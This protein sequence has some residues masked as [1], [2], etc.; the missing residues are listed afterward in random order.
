MYLAF[1]W[2]MPK[3]MRQSCMCACPPSSWAWQRGSR[4]QQ[5]WG[6]GSGTTATGGNAAC[7]LNHCVCS[8]LACAAI[9]QPPLTMHTTTAAPRSYGGTW[10]AVRRIGTEE[11]LAGY[12]K[13]MR[14][15][16]VQTAINAALMLMI[17][18]QASC[19]W[20]GGEG[21]V[22]WPHCSRQRIMSVMSVVHLATVGAWV[23]G[24]DCCGAC[25]VIA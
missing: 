25:A 13:G 16:I 6:A 12:F 17:K 24:L 11:G 14:A 19:M 1:K 9:L 5:W 22:A 20:A 3:H 2:G 8:I 15:K 10:D 21:A 18:D 7:V 23:G 4:Q